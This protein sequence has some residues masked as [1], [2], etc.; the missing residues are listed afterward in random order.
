MNVWV[1]YWDTPEKKIM[2]VVE[3]DALADYI[4]KL[5]ISNM[6]LDLQE[7]ASEMKDDGTRIRRWQFNSDELC[8][9]EKRLVEKERT[10]T[11]DWVS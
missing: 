5:Q 9:E 11:Y 7:W 10:Q 1:M 8:A 6:V 3:D 4:Q 2:D